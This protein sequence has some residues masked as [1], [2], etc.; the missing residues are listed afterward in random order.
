MRLG[1]F[2]AMLGT[3]APPISDFQVTFGAL[4]NHTPIPTVADLPPLLSVRRLLLDDLLLSQARTFP[5]IT[6]VTGQTVRSL[7]WTDDR[8][9][10]VAGS[11]RITGA[12]WLARGDTV[13]G[14]D[15]RHSLVARLVNAAE[16]D[17]V[18]PLLATYYR[19]YRGVPPHQPVQ[20]EAYR[21]DAGGSCYLFPNDS[22]LWTLA[23]SFPQEQF[24]TVRQNYEAALAEQIT[25]K[26]ELATRLATA[27][28]ATAWQGA[29][30][31][32][33][34]FRQPYGPGWA[35]VGDAG[36]HRDPI[37]ARGIP[38]ALLSASLLAAALTSNAD[39]TA[40]LADYQA[41]RDAA[42]Q[43]LYDLTVDRPPV[44]FTTATWSAA[45]GQILTDPAFLSTY[46][47][48]MAGAVPP[49]VLYTAAAAPMSER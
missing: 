46:I 2:D 13:I 24:A 39:R 32:T 9:T 23:I 30:D 31:L 14:A 10:G 25:R 27:T 16:Y 35:L 15:G 7:R 20:L 8:V 43:P 18:P 45:I 22:D 42:V 36:Y 11:D 40:A 47:G 21:D 4:T 44:G 5:Q 41:A 29:G 19:Y 26:P 12:A 34:R 33:N 28:A 17:L 38:D 49:A 6:L 48:V 1:I 37:T 3:G